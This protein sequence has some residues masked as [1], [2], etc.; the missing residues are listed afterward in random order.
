MV[1]RISG[2]K[3]SNRI[4]TADGIKVDPEKISTIQD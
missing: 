3:V 2:R 1:V 4:L